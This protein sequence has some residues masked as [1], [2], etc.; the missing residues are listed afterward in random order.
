MNRRK[1]WIL[2]VA[3]FAA[4][5]LLIAGVW[6]LRA[7]PGESPQFVKPR[8]TVGQPSPMT[9]RNAQNVVLIVLDTLRADRV[10]AERNGVPLMPHLSRFARDCLQFTHANTPC[11]WT[12]PAMASILTSLYVDTHQVFYGNN[13]KESNEAKSD[14]LSKSFENMATYLKRAGYATAVIQT[15]GNL[16]ADFGFAEGFDSYEYLPGDPAADVVSP[17][18]IA[19]LAELR[20]PFFFYVHFMDPHPPY[21]P[22][23]KCRDLFGW[24]PPIS[25]EELAVV[26][27]ADD[28]FMK[29]LYDHCDYM[30]GNKPKPSFT[31]L[32]PAAQEAVRTLYDGEVRSLDDELA[33]LIDALLKEKP[34]SIIIVLADHGEHLWEHGYMGHGLTMYEEELRVPLFFRSPGLPPQVVDREVS[35]VDVLPTVAGLLGLPASR[36]WQGRSL[37]SPEPDNALSPVFSHTYA[38][39]PSLNTEV[40]AL[41][42]GRLKLIVDRKKNRAELYDMANDSHEKTDLAAQRPDVV[43]TFK[44]LLDEH[45]NQNIQARGGVQR[46]SVGVSP[47]LQDQLRRLGYGQ[48]R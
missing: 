31:P 9:P 46:Q 28:K 5:L 30:V 29:Y 22:P 2:A 36:G 3:A 44:K 11:T 20:E 14:A 18:A 45:R 38:P 41:K 4:F 42:M 1:H 23:Q 48:A 21:T 43:A 13:P 47:D 24:P 40:E 12:R 33:K 15:N 10:F 16:V 25:D 35:I 27:N 32:S 37:L 34:N 26:N 6:M 19:R 8:Q 7:A 39:Y 17:H